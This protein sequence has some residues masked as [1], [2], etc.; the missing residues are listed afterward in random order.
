MEKIKEELK[1]S[2]ELSNRK[3][4][5]YNDLTNLSNIGGIDEKDEQEIVLLSKEMEQL[6]INQNELEDKIKE[7]KK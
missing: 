6:K 5:R 2:R 4:F 1:K 3:M 7:L